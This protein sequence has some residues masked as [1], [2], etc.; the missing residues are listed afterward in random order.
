MRQREGRYQILNAMVRD[1]PG[2]Y[3]AIVRSELMVRQFASA[4]GTPHVHEGVRIRNPGKITCGRNLAIGDDAMLQAG[5]GLEFGDDVLLGPGVKIWTQTH[6]TDSI[7]IPIQAQG[8]SYA[9]VSI[10]DDCWIG[11]NA[12]IMPGVRLPRGCV[13]AAGSVVGVKAYREYAILIGNPA[14]PIRYRDA[15]RGESAPPDEQAEP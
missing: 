12:F 2:A 5:G 6:V 4:R 14:R 11:A 3:G 13:V 15:P 1:L 7:E 8:Y 10:G 9:A